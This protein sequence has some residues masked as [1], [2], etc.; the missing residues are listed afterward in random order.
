MVKQLCPLPQPL[1]ILKAQ[2]KCKAGKEPLYGGYE[3]ELGKMVVGLN[4]FI[5][6]SQ[7]LCAEAEA[8]DPEA[9]DELL[10]QK[11]VELAAKACLAEHHLHGAK[12]AKSRFAAMVATPK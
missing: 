12:A 11:A 9:D 6:E 8:L 5:H 10:K 3:A 2:I 4:K 1:Q 7:E